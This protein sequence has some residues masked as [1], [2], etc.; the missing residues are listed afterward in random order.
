MRRRNIDFLETT[1]DMLCTLFHEIEIVIP[2]LKIV[3]L[4]L[5]E[6]D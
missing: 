4:R 3:E 1:L 2:I 6:M 5:E